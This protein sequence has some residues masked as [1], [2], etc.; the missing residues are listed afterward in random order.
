MTHDHGTAS[1]AQRIAA[2]LHSRGV[3]TTPEEVAE[4]LSK[5]RLHAKVMRQIDVPE[6]AIADALERGDGMVTMCL[7][8]KF[9]DALRS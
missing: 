1:P 5:Y 2:L 9:G 4:W 8:L 3:E 6:D 7:H